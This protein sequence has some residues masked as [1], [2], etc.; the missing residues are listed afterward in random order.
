MCGNFE[1]D[2]TQS[3]G[4]D[5]PLTFHAICYFVFWHIGFK[6]TVWATSMLADVKN[7]FGQTQFGLIF[8]CGV[9][10]SDMAPRVDFA[11]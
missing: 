8:G 6:P 5:R 4:G 2:G 3:S 9:A 11:R 7:D 10:N 1:P